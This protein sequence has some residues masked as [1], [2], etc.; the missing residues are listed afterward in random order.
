MTWPEVRSL[1]STGAPGTWGSMVGAT[2]PAVAR[3]LHP[4]YRV[5]DGET[6]AVRW[7]QLG[8]GLG[9]GTSWFDLTGRRLHSGANG[10]GWDAEPAVGPL[11][12][13]VTVP[14]LR[15]LRAVQE[16]QLYVG[17]WNGY[18]NAWP[19]AQVVEAGNRG[20]VL[21]V[22]N[23]PDEIDAWLLRCRRGPSRC[24]RSSGPIRCGGCSTR[25]STFPAR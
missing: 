12:P 16:A 20:W 13:A 2:W 7:A 24:P 21:T 22:L 10:P 17:E 14:L 4:A 23:G 9:P 18:G 5:V 8:S 25:T 6:T 15:R 1:L 11:D 19:L 3:V